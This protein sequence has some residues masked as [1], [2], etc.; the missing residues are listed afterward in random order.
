MRS[1]EGKNSDCELQER[2]QTRL[3]SG[4]NKRK[5]VVNEINLDQMFTPNE[6]SPV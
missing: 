5:S 4:K 1:L 3:I 2:I 6:E